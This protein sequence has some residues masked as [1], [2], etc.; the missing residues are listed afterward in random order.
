M[1]SVF[2]YPSPDFFE[3][4]SLTDLEFTTRLCWLAGCQTFLRGGWGLYL[5]LHA[6]TVRTLLPKHLF[7]PLIQK[8]SC[9]SFPVF[10][11]CSLK[12]LLL[13]GPLAVAILTAYINCFGQLPHG[14]LGS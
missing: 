1:S 13:T 14:A 10:C 4:E 8:A 11:L 6:S 7:S 12:E 9:L 2:L 3:A 5:G